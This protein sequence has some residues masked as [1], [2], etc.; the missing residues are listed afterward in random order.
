[1]SSVSLN[2]EKRAL[3]TGQ[4]V[5]Y[6]YLRWY[7]SDG[8]RRAKSIGRTDEISK[9][10][11]NK[12][13]LRKM[14]EL[15]LHPGRLGSIDGPELGVFVD[16]YLESRKTEV[17]PATVSIEKTSTAY[18]LQHFGRRR[19]IGK[20][21]RPEARKFREALIAGN[22]RAATEDWARTINKSGADKHVRH[23]C[24]MF[25]RAVDD[26]LIASNPF[27]KIAKT[28]QVDRAWP[29]VDQK[30]LKKLLVA[31]P[32]PEWQVFLALCRL[33]G[34]RRNEALY[35]GSDRIHGKRLQ[36]I[37]DGQW[38][39][40]DKDPRWVPIC[41]EL[42]KVLA[43]APKGRLVGD[44]TNGK[45]RKQWP[46]ILKKARVKTYAKP[47]QSLRKSCIRDWSMKHPS[48]VVRQWSGHG[49]LEVMDKYYLQTPASEYDRAA[50]EKLLPPQ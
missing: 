8:R 1:M 27:R 37:A 46:K 23:I 35:L 44:L 34:L 16:D 38:Q 11:A 28:T 41:P 13:R 4:K 18:L 3:K 32:N 20:I 21:T 7:G 12:I 48:H 29:Y 47:F 24:A 19:R 9:T 30:K 6:W 39:P 40:K 45:I 50:K 31:C 25:S 43:K 49:S 10:K 2:T 36:V 26:D 5:E 42:R 17:S 22:L 33:A 14:A 15:E